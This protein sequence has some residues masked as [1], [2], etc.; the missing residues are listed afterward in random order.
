[1]K[2]KQEMSRKYAGSILALVCMICLTAYVILKKND[3]HELVTAIKQADN[4]F[5]FVSVGMVLIHIVCEG[6]S[7]Q[8]FSNALNISMKLWD[9]VRYA[10]IDLYYCAITPSATGGQPV[11]AYYM[12][13]DHIPIGKTSVVL[14]MYTVIYKVILLAL[15]LFVLLFQHEVIFSHGKL[16]VLLFFVGVAINSGTI[17]VCQLCMFSEKTAHMIVTVGLNILTMLHITKNSEKKKQ[18]L[19]QHLKEYHLGA[20]FIREHVSVTMKVMAVTLVQRI[21]LFSVGYLV[22]RS[23]GFYGKTFMD[24]LALQ[25]VLSIGVDALPIPGAAGVTEAMF[26]ILYRGIYQ[27]NFIAPAMI[28]TRGITFYLCLFI[29]GAVTM[30]NQIVK[31]RWFSTKGDRIE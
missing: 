24:I 28:V 7:I 21:C 14:L 11:L 1:M 25:V 20:M 18:R 5:L 15:G 30:I 3:L 22:Y 10:C 16:V 9:G 17:L 31:V 29:S 19:E 2:T 26:V 13:R 6:Y 27:R 8:L 12:S 23:F 4:R